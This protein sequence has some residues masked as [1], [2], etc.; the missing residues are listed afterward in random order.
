[1][2]LLAVDLAGMTTT[3]ETFGFSSSLVVA[4]A[5][6]LLRFCADRPI[7]CVHDFLAPFNC[8]FWGLG[9]GPFPG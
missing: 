2:S 8:C 1:M 6:K 7:F 5:Y 9:V 3:E 4:T